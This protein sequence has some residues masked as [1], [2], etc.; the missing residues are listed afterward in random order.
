MQKV[1]HAILSKTLITPYKNLI[2]KT[3]EVLTEVIRKQ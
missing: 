1:K 3:W 2:S